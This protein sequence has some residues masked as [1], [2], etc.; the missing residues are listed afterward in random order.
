VIF[1]TIQ[2]P[3]NIPTGIKGASIKDNFKFSKFIKFK[4]M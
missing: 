1:L 3:K 4:G 2:N